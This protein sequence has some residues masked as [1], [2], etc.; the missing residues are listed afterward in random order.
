MIE[1]GQPHFVMGG[2]GHQQWE[3]I[4]CSDVQPLYLSKTEDLEF[5][6]QYPYIL[7]HTPLCHNTISFPAE[8]KKGIV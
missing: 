5:R 4:L 1:P 2:N 7:F 6:N 3:N 8:V